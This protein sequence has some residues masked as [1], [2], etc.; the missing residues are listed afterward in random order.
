MPREAKRHLPDTSR[1]S[2]VFGGVVRAHSL[3]RDELRDLR[4][5]R[6]QVTGLY[7]FETERGGPLSVDALPQRCPRAGSPP[8]GSGELGLDVGAA[9]HGYEAARAELQLSLR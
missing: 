2:V 3:D 4:K 8:S 9:V 5:L 6:Q 1:N 7:V